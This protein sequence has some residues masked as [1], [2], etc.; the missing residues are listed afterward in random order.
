MRPSIAKQSVSRSTRPKL[1]PSD[2]SWFD[3][4]RAINRQCALVELLANRL[5]EWESEYVSAPNAEGTATGYLTLASESSADLQTQIQC[6]Y[7]TWRSEQ[8]IK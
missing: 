1:Q 2:V 8:E 5:S 6:A 7:N 3:L 4:E